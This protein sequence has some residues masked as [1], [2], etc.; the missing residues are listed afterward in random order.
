ML[1]M[2]D[3]LPNGLHE[4][5]MICSICYIT[6]SRLDVQFVKKI[7]WKS[8][9]DERK[10]VRSKL[11]MVFTLNVPFICYLSRIL[12]NVLRTSSIK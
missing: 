5:V 3:F 9:T 8:S 11:I 1:F 2:A 7:P 4:K 10:G 12:I 6:K